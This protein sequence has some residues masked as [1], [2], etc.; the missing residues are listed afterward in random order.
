[1][2]EVFP[3]LESIRCNDGLF[4][5]LSYHQ[6]RV[7]HTFALLWPG[8]KAPDLQAFLNNHPVPDRGLYKCRLL[9]GRSVSEPVYQ[10]YLMRPPEKLRLLAANHISYHL[11][12][13]NRDELNSMFDMRGDCDDVLIVRNGLIT[14]TTYC[15]IA[16]LRNGLWFTP[17]VPLLE[18]VR[19]ASLL[20]QGLV[21]PMTITAEQL[22]L[23]THFKVFNAM[24]GWD[25][26]PPIPV[27]LIKSDR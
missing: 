27:S 18:G 14:D 10:H 24:I 16:F 19:R 11:K 3:L 2:T 8:Q 26:C 6:Q 22:G 7:Q 25:D 21:K 23:F 12:W 1:M 9:Y 17:V 20:D 15:N 5:L 4:P 13:T